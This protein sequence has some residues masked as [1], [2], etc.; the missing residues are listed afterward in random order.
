MTERIKFVINGVDCYLTFA[1]CESGAPQG[2]AAPDYLRAAGW[3][4]E[5]PWTTGGAALLP[6]GTLA[7]VDHPT[8][9]I[10]WAELTAYQ[11]NDTWELSLVW[12][13]KPCW[14]AYG[15]GDGF[16]AGEETRYQVIARPR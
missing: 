5:A 16:P 1:D 4:P 2:R 10:V 3:A 11:E 6:K 7:W 8:H 15:L 13:D 12:R 9:G 14:V